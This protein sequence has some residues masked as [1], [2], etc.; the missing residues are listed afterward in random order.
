[1]LLLSL[2]I[3]IRTALLGKWDGATLPERVHLFTQFCTEHNRAMEVYTQDEDWSEMKWTWCTGLPYTWQGV[4]LDQ[5]FA[6]SDEDSGWP[7][8]KLRWRDH[9]NAASTMRELFDQ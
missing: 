5:E 2:M 9:G 8:P 7:K 4:R 6:Q 1:L 3:D